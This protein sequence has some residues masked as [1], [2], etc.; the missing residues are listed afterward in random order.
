MYELIDRIFNH[1]LPEYGYSIRPDQIRLCKAIFAGLTSKA[2]Y[3]CEAEV[4][5]GK[6]LAYLIACVVL[7]RYRVTTMPITITTSTV[8]LQR[9]LVEREI[10]QLSSILLEAG[11][12][13]QPLT[14]ILR[15]GREHYF[16]ISRYRRFFPGIRNSADDQLKQIA[17]S[18]SE[19]FENTAFDL[20]QVD[21]PISIKER[22]CVEGGCRDCKFRRACKYIHFVQHALNEAVPLTFQVT[23]HNLYL[24]SRQRPNLLRPSDFIIV[25]EAHKLKEAAQSAFGVQISEREI[26]SYLNWSKTLCPNQKKKSIYAADQ[27][28][29]RHMNMVLFSWLHEKLCYEDSDA[30]AHSMIVLDAKHLR[31]IE[32]MIETIEGLETMRGGFGGSSMGLAHICNALEV[33][34]QQ[35]W[36]AT[37]VEQDENGILTLCGCPRKLNQELKASVWS[38]RKSHVLLSGTMS[39]EDD[40]RYFKRELGLNLLSQEWMDEA[41]FCSPFDYAKQMRLYLADDLPFP[42]QSEPYFRAISN[43]IVELVKA[44]N[45]HTAILFTSYRAL[46]RVFELTKIRLR[47]YEVIRMTRSNRTAIDEFRKSRNGVLFASGSMWEGVDCVGD[48]L[49]S[50]IIV[51]LPFPQRSAVME[52]KR[53]SCGST[54]DFIKSYAVPEMLIKL[55]QGA[56][57]LIR[58]ETDTG[59]LAI[60]DVRAAKGRHAHT[61]QQT[62]AKYPRVYSVEDV[63]QFIRA[64]KPKEYFK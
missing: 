16:C 51:R 10:P 48:C 33:L 18:I 26:P 40:F 47:D 54:G 45:G 8:E 12:I 37:W 49:S 35:E 58:S 62:L 46:Q 19:S 32:I 27:K 9:A 17:E 13:H 30:E 2:V 25:D 42:D 21:L 36:V 41:Q 15:K 23:N 57:R 7:Q 44:T 64:V 38:Y 22:I 1:I 6:T 60:L 24:M 34:R 53:D 28:S 3:L 59:V 55:R 14:S 11:V 31:L 29:L 52:M 63:G 43:R 61:V 39:A 20:D 4:G 56:G 50:V 5:S